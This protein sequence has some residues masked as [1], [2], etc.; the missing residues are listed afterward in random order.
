MSTVFIVA[1]L[2]GLPVFYFGVRSRSRV[3]LTVLALVAAGIA[4]STGNS[5]Y[6]GSDLA[7]VALAWILGLLVL[8]AN[9]PTIQV[10]EAE[11]RRKAEERWAAFVRGIFISSVG[12]VMVGGIIWVSARHAETLGPC[13]EKELGRRNMSLDQCRINAEYQQCREG[14]REACQRIEARNSGPRQSTDQSYRW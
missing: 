1:L 12:L 9:A 10:D 3:L 13:S 6:N 2:H 11:R 4:L 7:A 8:N 14:N 5:R